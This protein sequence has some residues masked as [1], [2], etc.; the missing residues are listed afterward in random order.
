MKKTISILTA[1]VMM[2]TMALPLNA[3]AGDSYDII[4]NDCIATFDMSDP[5]N[6][7]E[8]T[9]AEAGTTVYLIPSIDEGNYVVNFTLDG[10]AID[11]RSFVMPNQA[12]EVSVLIGE[13]TDV[14]FSFENGTAGIDHSLLLYMTDFVG[15]VINPSGEN[16]AATAAFDIDKDEVADID[17]STETDTLY[18]TQNIMTYLKTNVLKAVSVTNTNP[19]NPYGKITFDF[20]TDLHN[21]PTYTVIWKLDDGSEFARA[22]NV[23]EGETVHCEKTPAKAMTPIYYYE[24]AGWSPAEGAITADTVYTA[25]FTQK[26]RTRT[27]TWKNYNG[28]VLQTK[29]IGVTQSVPAYTGSKPTRPKD[30]TFKYTFSK[31]ATT[32]DKTT[33][34]VVCTAQYNKSELPAKITASNKTYKQSQKT[35]QYTVT[36]KIDGKV[37]KGKKLTLKVSNKTYTAKTNTKGK[38]IFKIKNLTKKGTY[39]ATISYK[40]KTKTTSKKATIKVK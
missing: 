26:E 16:A 10:V 38:A 20:T 25:T 5:E 34:D 14:S 21:I 33:G 40:G 18:A 1:L 19:Y 9:Q 13:K 17:F 7:W 31:W 8:E 39:K 35:K 30:A 37:A 22:T 24:F 15:D 29:T 6:I 27:V 11:G 23:P 32:T 3:F 12:V 36:L 4:C 28:K 2:I